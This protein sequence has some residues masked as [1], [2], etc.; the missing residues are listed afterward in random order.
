[1]NR[2]I[3][4]PDRTVGFVP[5]RLAEAR[6]AVQM[7]RAELA[8]ELGLTGQAIGFYEAGERRP[9]MSILLRMAET[10]KQ[11]VSFFLRQ[12]PQIE[13]QRGTR[14]FRS[15]G[16][17]SNKINH[18]LDVRAK[19]LWEL[20]SA[21]GE[22]IR[23]PPHNLPHAEPAK[24]ES[25][26][27]LEEIEQLATFIRRHWSMG[28]GP[29][30]NVA[31][32]LETH[33][34]IVTRFE[35]GSNEIDAFSCW[36]R[37]RPYIFLGSDKKSCSRSRF[38][39]AH[40]LGHLLLHVDIS[41]EDLEDKKI[42][43]RIEHEAN[44]FAGAF[45]LPRPSMLREFYSTR[46]PHLQG[47]K[48][49]WR[50]SMQAIAHRAKS[51]GIIDDNQYILFRKQISFHGWTKKE[52]L[53]DEIPMEQPQWLLKCWNL[54]AVRRGIDGCGVEDSLGFT[55]DRVM[56]L[57]GRTEIPPANRGEP[58]AESSVLRELK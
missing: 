32:L 33:G 38:D 21:V 6:M 12:G 31:A 26:Y 44:M 46:T 14:F 16:S 41:Q 45:L 53:D 55:L 35:L 8:R 2:I 50:V 15:I 56:E 39:A 49:R 34:V 22:E 30:A 57:F 17:R 13:F 20:V 42:R 40:E 58:P 37:K 1:M 19:W 10:L 18:A 43:D 51:I 29:I 9:D 11:P 52:P 23:L 27:C 5:H 4:F 24:S 28:D 48:Q 7:S 3:S 54:F 36:I 47:M 25:G